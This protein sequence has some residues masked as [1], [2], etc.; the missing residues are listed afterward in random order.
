MTEPHP[1]SPQPEQP[2]PWARP[3]EGVPEQP[4]Q[5]GPPQ[6]GQPQY[7][8]PP[9]AHWAY[10]PQQA[11]P[12]QQRS[13]KPIIAIIA[14]AVVLLCAGTVVAGV[15]VFNQA[16]NAAQDVLP[17]LPPL[18]TGAP[19]PTRPAPTGSAPA[20]EDPFQIPGLPDLDDLLPTGAGV[21]A[22][23]DATVVYEVTGPDDAAVTYTEAGTTPKSERDVR[24]PW[25]KEF[26][27]GSETPLLSVTGIHFGTENSELTCRIT[28]DGK[29]IVKRTA[30]GNASTATCM[31]FVVVS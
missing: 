23:P 16:R 2:N 31:Q 11:P 20:T 14:A 13:V 25:R 1:P 5:Y 30:S 22:S 24:L 9:T 15:L 29:E 10:D 8:P 28:L 12:P 17:S 18:P 3:P 21:T 7:A 19:E 6:Y 27:L 4:V 26:T